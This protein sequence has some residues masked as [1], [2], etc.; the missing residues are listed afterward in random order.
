M[1][2]INYYEQIKN[3]LISNEIY[4][5]VKEY[6]IN[7]HDLMTY[8]NVGKLIVEAQ[9]GNERAKYGDGLI[10]EFSK[11]LIMEVN[12]K[13][14]ITSL[15]RMRKFYQ[16]IQKGAPLEHQLHWNHYKILITIKD[17]NKT[18]YYIN[19]I[20]KRKLSKRQLQD[21]I[22]NKEYERLSN[23]AKLKLQD[24]SKLSIEDYIKDPIIINSEKNIVS[25]KVLKQLILED[26]DNFLIQLGDG[27]SYIGNE[28]KI[29]IDNRPNYI[30][31][32]LFNIKYN[33]YVVI[34]LKITEV[35]KEHIGQIQV[36][37]NYINNNLKTIY[38]N[39]TIGLIIAKKKNNFVISYSSDKRIFETTYIT[40]QKESI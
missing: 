12:K 28:Y 39:N 23:E 34:E 13:Y 2:I 17:I 33:C 40:K 21:I 9:E 3:L 29:I 18:K 24:N 7:K 11:K 20:I 27:Y 4:K 5:N 36:Y 37:M 10:K 30:D 22:K 25:E 38:Q 16:I 8:Y 31:I 35:K 19:E 26:L 32:L 1:I 6:S 15:K 14:D